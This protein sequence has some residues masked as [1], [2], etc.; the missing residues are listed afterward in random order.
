[1]SAFDMFGSQAYPGSPDLGTVYDYAAPQASPF[2]DPKTAALLGLAQGLL[3]AGAPT[4]VPTG[5]GGAL[6]Q[7]IGGALSGAMGAQQYQHQAA[8]NDYLGQQSAQLKQAAA[9]A[10]RQQEAIN[11]MA[12][13][14]PADKRALFLANPGAFIKSATEFHPLSPGQVLTQG[15]SEVIRVKPNLV[16]VNAG[17]VTQMVSPDT[18]LPGAPAI[19]HSLPPEANVITPAKAAELRIQASNADPLGTLG[20]NGIIQRAIAAA[21][22]PG[23]KT[24]ATGPAVQATTPGTNGGIPQDVHGDDFLGKLP[25]STADQVKALAEGRMQFPAGFALKSPYWQNMI[26]MVSQYDPNF[27]AINYQSRAATRKDF[28]SGASSKNVT[29]IN[30]AIGHLDSLDKAAS[31]LDNGSTPFINS[32]KNTVLPQLG[33]T[34]KAANLRTFQ[35][36]KEAVANELMRV[37]RGTGASSSDTQKWAETI[38]AADSPPALKAAIRSAVDLLDSRITALDV[39]Y[40]RGMGTTASVMDLINPKTKATYERLHNVGTTQTP[41]GGGIK[42]LGFE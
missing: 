29:A 33:G 14:L 28:T 9:T 3:K 17:G 13:Q 25:K 32:I 1:M 19:T 18:G 11:Q 15:G 36:A 27:D 6:S 2:G 16:P 26:S 34:Q 40:K 37:F 35:Q 22:T 41:A 23:A 39:Q 5:L 12:A 7:G 8:V 38:N 10:Q 30:T 31:A 42:F 21:G 4:S 24:L 20:L